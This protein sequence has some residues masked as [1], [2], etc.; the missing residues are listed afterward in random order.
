MLAS[1][2][3]EG[4]V[5][6]RPPLRDKGGPICQNRRVNLRIAELS[7]PKTIHILITGP[8]PSSAS[9]STLRGERGL[10]ALLTTF[11]TN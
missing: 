11:I 2:R 7:T 8:K 10:T 4:C 6:D 1:R 3:S 9:E 5:V